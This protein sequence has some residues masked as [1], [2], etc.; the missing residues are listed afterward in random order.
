M[1]QVPDFP[2]LPH[3]FPTG[4]SSLCRVV[5]FVVLV[6]KFFLLQHKLS[7]VMELRALCFFSLVSLVSVLQASQE[8]PSVT[9]QCF[10][11]GSGER[12]SLRGKD[13][14]Q[15]LVKRAVWSCIQRRCES[16]RH[17][18]RS[19]P[20]LGPFPHT[21]AMMVVDFGGISPS[22]SGF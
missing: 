18:I 9:V 22:S 19:G 20:E 10:V 15:D 6:V 5:N 13:T 4:S 17:L 3:L 14:K 12:H 1:L 11:P 7:R 2:R 16:L 8:Y 21:L